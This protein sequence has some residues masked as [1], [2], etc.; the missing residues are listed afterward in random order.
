M[1]NTPL[2]LYIHVPFCIQKC[3]YCDFNSYA[4]PSHDLEKNYIQALINDFSSEEELF[5]NRK[6]TSIFIGGGTP[7]LF[8]A[9]SYDQLLNAITTKLSLGASAEITIEINPGTIDLKK[10]RSYFN[11]GINRLSIG[12][13]SFQNEKLKILQRIHSAQDA[14]R[15]LGFAK[16]VGFQNINIDLMYGIPRQT[17]L[18]AL[19]DLETATTQ[20]PTHLS[21][22]QLTIEHNTPFE[23]SAKQLH[24]PNEEEIFR[25]QKEGQQYLKSKN[26]IHYEISAYSKKNFVCHHNL[27]YWLFGDYLGIGAGA[28]GKITIKNTAPSLHVIRY[29]KFN[30]PHSYLQQAKLNNFIAEKHEVKT[31]DLPF[32]FMMNALR[33]IQGAPASLF[34]K[35][36]GIAIRAINNQLEKATAMGFIRKNR[37]RLQITK[38]GELFLNDCLQIFL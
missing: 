20:S 1:N 14:V 4:L 26:Y 18:D 33:L 28:H 38:R 13:Q 34:E 32:E 25:M 10:M 17:T 2:T 3:P 27:N 22:Y 8:S 30:H 5:Q 36:T 19:A 37:S 21:W 9:E 7:S 35:R 16:K 11:L 15:T 12:V 23:A 29:Q 24:L 31:N 6:L